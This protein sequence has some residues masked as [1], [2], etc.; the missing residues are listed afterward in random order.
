MEFYEVIQSRESIRNY[1]PQRP[2]E[3]EKLIRILEAGRIAPSAANRQPYEFWLIS[4]PEMISAVRECYH[5]D[6][7]KNAPLVL[8]V[9]GK[10]NEAWVRSTDGY[11][12]IETDTAIAMTHI[13]L[14]AE[15]EG[16]GTCWIANFNP[17][18]MRYAF[19]LKENQV[20]FGI[21][22]LGYPQSGFTRKGEKNRK[23]FEEVVKFL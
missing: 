9:V 8:V 6:W 5:H 1:D 17:E 14:A 3:K 13:I 2:V 19:G 7:Y 23:S 16:I 21:T 11:T 12:A 15:N 10:K 22:P 4:S 20:I 18:K